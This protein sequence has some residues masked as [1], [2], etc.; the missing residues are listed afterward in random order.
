MELPRNK[1]AGK[2]NP[3]YFLHCCLTRAVY[4]DSRRSLEG[5]MGSIDIDIEWLLANGNKET[6]VLKRIGETW[7]PSSTARVL[8]YQR[9]KSSC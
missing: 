5:P 8:R 7:T 6:H 1:W 2:E 3:A 9:D 4:L